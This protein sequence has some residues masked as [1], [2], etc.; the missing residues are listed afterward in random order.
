MTATDDD[1]DTLT[2]SLDDQGGANFEID[3][4]GQ[5]KTKDALNYE[6]TPS[7]S[8]DRVSPRQEGHQRQH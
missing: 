7:Y 4:N 1:G 6:T 3:S 8:G 2:Y 5:I